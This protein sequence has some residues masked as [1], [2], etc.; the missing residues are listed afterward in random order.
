M[1]QASIFV[2]EL[3]ATVISIEDTGDELRDSLVTIVTDNTA[4]AQVMI[5]KAS[6][7]PYGNELVRRLLRQCQ[8]HN[9]TYRVVTCVSAHNPADAPSRNLPYEE[10]RESLMWDTV[11]LFLQQ[12]RN[13]G[14]RE[15]SPPIRKKG[16]VKHV[17]EEHDDL[18]EYSDEEL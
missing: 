10:G 15:A 11:D 6:A 2:K 7:T 17:E 5:R 12:M 18:T 13:F 9:I 14:Q 16:S 1:A 4:S 3:A 8:T